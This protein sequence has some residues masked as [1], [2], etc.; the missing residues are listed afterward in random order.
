MKNYF[1]YGDPIPNDLKSFLVSKFT[2][3]SCS[4]SYTVETCHHFKTRV[5]EHIKKY[6]KSHIFNA[7][8]NRTKG[9]CHVIHI[10]LGSCFG[11]VWVYQIS[12][13]LY[14]RPFCPHPW[15][16]SKRLILDRVKYFMNLYK[17]MYCKTIFLFSYWWYPYIR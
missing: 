10:F 6:N 4:S 14:D 1:S 16:A 8:F 15:P 17:S 9:V 7:D 2:C 3:V 5:V 12:L 11:Q 13:L